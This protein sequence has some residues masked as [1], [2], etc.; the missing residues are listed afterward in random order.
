MTFSFYLRQIL[1]IEEGQR[2]CISIFERRYKRR[3]ALRSPGNDKQENSSTL[4]K[5]LQRGHSTI[6]RGKKISW[7]PIGSK[8]TMNY[9]FSCFNKCILKPCQMPKY[10]SKQCNCDKQPAII[11][12][13]MELRVWDAKWSGTYQTQINIS[14]KL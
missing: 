14:G 1:Q 2:Q 4:N 9:S 11:P 3:P 12:V 6:E 8:V 7:T 13:V 5:R 10:N